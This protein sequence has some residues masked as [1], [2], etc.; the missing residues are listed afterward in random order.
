MRSRFCII[1]ASLAAATLL[2]AQDPAQ[3]PGSGK[4][5]RRDD[6]LNGVPAPAAPINSAGP[7]LLTYHGGSVILGQT[8]IYY[9]WYGNWSVDVN[10]APILNAFANNLVGS[11]Y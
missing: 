9:I 11:P 2:L 7:I 5:S 4:I 1:A 8:H 10:A 3:P 6:R